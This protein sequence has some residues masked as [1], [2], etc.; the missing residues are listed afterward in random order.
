MPPA[1]ASSSS[2]Q[3]EHP[4]VQDQLHAL[5]QL[6]AAANNRFDNLL[7][8]INTQSDRLTLQHDTLNSMVT[9]LTTLTHSLNNRQ[10]ENHGHPPPPPPPPP[11]S[12]TTATPK[13]P[14]S[15]TENITSDIF[16]CQFPG[17][18]FQVEN[19]F[20]YYAIP[21]DQRLAL[22]VFYFI[23]DALSWYNH[24]SNN[25]LLGTWTEFTRALET[26]FGPSTYENHRATL[27]K[28]RQTSSV[29]AY[30]S[31]FEK[32]SN[33]VN[34]LP[35]RHQ[36]PNRFSFSTPTPSTPANTNSP[37]PTLTPL[38]PTPP[39]PQTKPLPYI[40][41]SDDALQKRRA[42]GLCFRCP[43]KYHP[44]HVC[45]PAQFLLIADNEDSTPENASLPPETDTTIDPTDLHLAYDTPQFMSLSA[46]AFYG[47]QSHRALRVTGYIHGQRVTTLNDCGRTHNIIQPRIAAMLQLQATPIPTFPVMIGNGADIILGLAWL[48][49]LGQVVADFAIPQLTFTV[50]NTT[51]VLTDEPMSTSISPSSLH[52]LLRTDT[53]ASL[54]TLLYHHQ[55]PSN[56]P[57]N[58]TPHPHADIEALLQHFTKLF[59][60]PH[61]LPPTSPHDHHI[62]LLPN[63]PPVNIKPYRYPH[64]QKEIM[65]NLITDMLKDG[66]I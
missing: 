18:A 62:P 49:T 48:S 55:T 7:T 53:I 3:D 22:S 57:T 35:P 32:I 52:S 66:V 21:Q 65:T 45:Q 5:I 43:D 30:Q 44:G 17:L 26:R 9:L 1:D 16:R 8:T 51:C 12:T 6:S 63:T 59:D 56:P 42:E 15:P 24:L 27:F 2:I 50:N 58:H 11:T 14:T 37:F 20:T 13:S 61:G 36:T 38:L 28:L 19:Y 47:L 39:S 64:Y 23:G 33:C 10:P 46:V 40:R 4:S 41:L 54:H 25:N 29:A 34:D 60:P 31:E